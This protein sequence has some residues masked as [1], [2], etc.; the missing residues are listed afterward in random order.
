MNRL[1]LIDMELKLFI[2]QYELRHG[3]TKGSA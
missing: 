3:V 1:D 2:Q